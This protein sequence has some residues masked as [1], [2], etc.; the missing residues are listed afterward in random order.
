MFLRPG[1]FGT[2]YTLIGMLLLVIAF[3]GSCFLIGNK[4]GSQI[5]K[6]Y[7]V[8]LTVFWV[9]IL[10]S[11]TLN[12]S[13]PTFLIKSFVTNLIFT[14]LTILLVLRIENV[15]YKVIDYYLYL[16]SFM[17]YSSLA[18]FLLF[19]LFGR[20]ESLILLELDVGYFNTSQILFPFSILYHEMH[21]GD[22]SVL[23]FQSIFRESGI[24]Q[25]FYLSAIVVSY[26]SNRSRP[27]IWGLILGLLMTFS[28]TG[29][30]I[31]VII[32]PLMLLL[33]NRFKG[34][35]SLRSFKW[36]SFFL[37]LPLVAYVT[38][39]ASFNIPYI[40]IESKQATHNAAIS[41]RLPELSSISLWGD[42]L[43][44]IYAQENSSINAL[45]A[46]ESIGVIGF[47]LYCFIFTGLCILG[48]KKH[49][50]K[51]F[52]SIL[53][54]FITSI[55]AQPLIDAPFIYILLFILRNIE[56]ENYNNHNKL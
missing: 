28:T 23:R 42:G 49:G 46:I 4:G 16:L 12:N 17:G 32:L 51:V 6:Y 47:V 35:E 18:S 52:L 24:A 20:L 7:L 11:G 44:S 37:F 21:S 22:F 36:I 14:S 31:A 29:I 1:I 39:E 56:Y 54:L 30:A 13:N 9:V 50:I 38:I 25:G 48:T 34:N 15:K 53:P 19:L 40:G 8:F 33:K 27:L 3:T 10:A 2:D 45:K 43:Y 26:F 5:D 55:F 41:D